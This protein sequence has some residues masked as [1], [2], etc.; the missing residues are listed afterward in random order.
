MAVFRGGEKGG[1]ILR[2]QGWRGWK[3]MKWPV[4]KGKEAGG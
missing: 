1:R 4:T 3:A 2:Q